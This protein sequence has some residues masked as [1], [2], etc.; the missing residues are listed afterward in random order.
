MYY[1]RESNN[2]KLI[3][4][5]YVQVYSFS[6]SILKWPPDNLARI[7]PL[8][9]QLAQSMKK[10]FILDGLRV[11]E[12]DLVEEAGGLWSLCRSS[13]R[14]LMMFIVFNCVLFMLLCCC[15]SC[16]LRLIRFLIL[17]FTVAIVSSSSFAFSAFS[18]FHSFAFFFTSASLTITQNPTLPIFFT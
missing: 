1:D 11:R 3:K 7:C 13:S 6:L 2:K 8:T 14:S 5:N 9:E 16:A 10:K 12:R 18:L 4:K 15:F 17:R